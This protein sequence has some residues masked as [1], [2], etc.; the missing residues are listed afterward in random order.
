MPPRVIVNCAMSAD[1]KI[2]SRM[3][4]QVRLSDEADMAR[5]HRLRN[6]CDA[7]LVGVGTVLADDP[8]LLV[9]VKYVDEVKQP[10]R[11]ILDSGCRIPREAKILDGA[12]RTLVFVTEG[13]AA[14]VPGA[15]VLTC[16][17]ERIDLNGML[18]ILG[19]MGI[20]TL[21]VEGGGRTIWSFVSAGLVDEF[22]VFISNRII[23]GANAP[24]PVDGEGFGEE[25]E[26]TNIRL[27]KT[28][29]SGS[30]VLLEF[31]RE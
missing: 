4:K 19:D 18:A 26:F 7:I 23:G 17:K 29:M 14:D 24:T 6:E 2:A 3:R 16:G 12:S 5:V 15:E 27:V 20:G 13:H 11:I 22:K 10:V 30:G 21:L 28:T 25:N 1:G 9:K 8:S 31:E